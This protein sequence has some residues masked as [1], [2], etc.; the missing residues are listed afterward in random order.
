[1]RRQWLRTLAA[2]LALLMVSTAHASNGVSFTLTCSG[3]T[4]HGGSIRASRDTSG[5]GSEAFVTTA[6]DG[7]GQIL[8]QSEISLPIN[9]QAQYNDSV[10]WAVA[11]Q[12]N[13]LVLEIVSPGG[14][15]QPDQLIYA[16]AG[17]CE[18]L[19]TYGAGLFAFGDHFALLPI[20]SPADGVTSPT[21]DPNAPLPRPVNPPGVAEAQPGYAIVA[22]DNLYLRSGDGAQFSPLGILDGGTRLI[23]LGQDGR[24]E[25]DRWWYVEVGGMQGWVRSSLLYLRGDLTGIPVIA[26]HG[27]LTQPTLYVGAQNPIYNM[28]SAGGGARCLIAGNRLYFVIGQDAQAA[29]WYLVEAACNGQTV[30]GWIQTNRG[31][32]RNPGG[33]D[34]PVAR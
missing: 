26:A 29:R 17:N 10:N 20:L 13:P 30:L 12:Y 9:Q 6:R 4:A 18:S 21:Y 23:V 2:A 14:N 27:I 15:G 16:A 1:M 5:N 8:Y 28:P 31:L 11:P 19:P 7:S 34:I 33:V 24:S 25:D 32:L 22:T 3:S